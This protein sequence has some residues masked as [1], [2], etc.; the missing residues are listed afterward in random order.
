MLTSYYGLPSRHASQERRICS[1]GH[2]SDLAQQYAASSKMRVA[3]AHSLA[4]EIAP[5]GTY[6][7]EFDVSRCLKDG[8]LTQGDDVAL[9]LQL[10]RALP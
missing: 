4:V 9:T 1:T 8:V 5:Y 6:G 3:N 10:G 7:V 2:G